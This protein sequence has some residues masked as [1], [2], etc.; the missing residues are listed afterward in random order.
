MIMPIPDCINGSFELFGGFFIIL[1]CM[2][3]IKDKAVKGV[4]NI[5]TMFF[6]SWG[7]W[8]L[9][10]YPSLDQWASFVGGVF[11]VTA[12]IAWIGLMLYYQKSKKGGQD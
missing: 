5:A 8:N 1:H 12:N 7:L 11:V 4:S 3:V 10:Y 6:V 2:R 9:Y